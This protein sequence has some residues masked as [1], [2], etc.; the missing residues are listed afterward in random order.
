[1]TYFLTFGKQQKRFSYGIGRR[2]RLLYSRR[3]CYYI[4]L[5]VRIFKY[6]SYGGSPLDSERRFI[7]APFKSLSRPRK[8]EDPVP[9]NEII[10]VSRTILRTFLVRKHYHMK[11][12]HIHLRYGEPTRRKEESFAEY[13]IMLLYSAAKFIYRICTY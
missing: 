9:F 8:K 1:M 2:Y 12:V 10:K 7:I 11:S 5:T 3:I 13:F 4:Q 6:L